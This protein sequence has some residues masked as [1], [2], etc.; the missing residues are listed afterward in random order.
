MKYQ[1]QELSK[2]ESEVVL[3]L[4]TGSNNFWDAYYNY[5]TRKKRMDRPTLTIVSWFNSTIKGLHTKKLFTFIP[6]V[7]KFKNNGSSYQFVWMNPGVNASKAN[8]QAL[9]LHDAYM[10]H[11][12]ESKK[13]L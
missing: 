3:F 11:K 8:Y 6:F 9:T 10:E 5:E 12:I 2:K 13:I 1:G 7:L 4:Q